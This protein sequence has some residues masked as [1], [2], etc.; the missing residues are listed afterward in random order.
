MMEGIFIFTILILTVFFLIPIL[1]I[2][3]QYR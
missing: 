2:P 1:S 3:V